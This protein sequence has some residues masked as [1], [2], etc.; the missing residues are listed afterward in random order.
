MKSKRLALYTFGI[1]RAPASDAVNQGFHDRNDRNFLHDHKASP[2]AFDFKTCFDEDDRPATIDS[3]R[4]KQ[5]M[6]L[7]EQRQQQPS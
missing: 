6:R 1:F 5:N 2:F 4:V 7:N 3:Q